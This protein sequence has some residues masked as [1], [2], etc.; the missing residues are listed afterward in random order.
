[1]EGRTNLQ[2]A[3]RGTSRQLT[4]DGATLLRDFQTME[5]RTGDL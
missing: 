3:I 5:Q 2:T 1:M 4:D